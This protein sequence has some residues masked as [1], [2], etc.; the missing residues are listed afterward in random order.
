MS[1]RAILEDFSVGGDATR[2][3]SAAAVAVL[4]SPAPPVP[5]S[6]DIDQGEGRRKHQRI[7]NGAEVR[8][9]LVE[10]TGTLTPAGTGRSI[11]VSR[12]GMLLKLKASWPHVGQKVV[13]SHRLA[14]VPVYAEVVRV[15]KGLLRTRLGLKFA[16]MPDALQ[17][18]L[19]RHAK[20]M[21]VWA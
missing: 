20:E 19:E 5:D 7:E 9:W 2:T 17:P 1:R 4:E 21:L 16:P 6:A 13:L 10:P 11:D 3:L 14:H 12:G 8:L 18:Q 15:S